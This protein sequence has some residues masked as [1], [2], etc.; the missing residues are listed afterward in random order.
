[1]CEKGLGQ[2]LAHGE[3]PEHLYLFMNVCEAPR[4]E[5]GTE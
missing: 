1:M 5:S 2:C 3:H 4:A